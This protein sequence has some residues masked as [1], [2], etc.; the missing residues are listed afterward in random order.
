MVYPLLVTA[1][2]SAVIV[3][4]PGYN[5]ADAGLERGS[6]IIVGAISCVIV[7]PIYSHC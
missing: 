7:L 3:Y 1:D 6:R 2:L 4:K 5:S